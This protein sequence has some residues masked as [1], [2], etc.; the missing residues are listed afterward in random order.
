M[1]EPITRT[2][3]FYKLIHICNEIDDF[4]Y[5]GSTSNVKCRKQQHKS[6]CNNP[7]YPGYNFK[8][9]QVIR[10]NGGFENFKMAILGTRENITKKEA[11]MVEEEYRKSE[12]ANLNMNNCYLAPEERKNYHKNYYKNWRE[13]NPDY[14][15]NWREENPDYHKNWREE[16]PDYYKNW[17]EAKKKA[18]QDI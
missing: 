16:N 9:Y 14:C 10:A 17:Y 5:V 7:N 12:R 1:S 4:V 15:K 8:L 6:N 3:T 18:A 13:E 11:L 2:Y